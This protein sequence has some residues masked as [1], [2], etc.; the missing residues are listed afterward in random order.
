[1]LGPVIPGQRAAAGRPAE[2]HLRAIDQGPMS[3]TGSAATSRAL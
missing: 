3:A 2:L 1:V